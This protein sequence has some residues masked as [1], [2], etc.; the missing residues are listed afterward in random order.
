MSRRKTPVLLRTRS[1]TVAGSALQLSYNLVLPPHLPSPSNCFWTDGK[2][3]AWLCDCSLAFSH[4]PQIRFRLYKESLF[5]SSLLPFQHYKPVYREVNC[6][7]NWRTAQAGDY[8]HRCLPVFQW[9][10]LDQSTEVPRY[11]CHYQGNM[12]MQVQCDSP[13]WSFLVR[14]NQISSNASRA[15]LMAELGRNARHFDCLEL[16]LSGRC[17]QDGLLKT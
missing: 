11:G 8:F 1:V 4:S 16:F 2:L 13:S 15:R 3:A 14:K 5:F 10:Q 12:T 7:N 17:S 9:A 6:S